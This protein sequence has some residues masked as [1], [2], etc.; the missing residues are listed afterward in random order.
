MA[1]YAVVLLST[2]GVA[3]AL[4]VVAGGAKLRLPSDA[5][6]ALSTVGI[7]V[8]DAAIRSLGLVEIAI[9]VWAA[10]RPSALTAALVVL[11]YAGFAVFVLASMRTGKRAPCGCFGAAGTE[12]GP[13]H[14]VLNVAGC[15]I[16]VAAALTPPPGLGWI[17]GR[18]PLTAVSLALGTAAAVIAAYMAF[19]ALP[20]AWRAYGMDQR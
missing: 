20:S 13:V 5:R 11:L 14:L 3:C 7:A 18:E 17:A 4:L 6:S 9:G 19:T 1:D 8:P 2:F 10:L 15:A 16:A 12:V